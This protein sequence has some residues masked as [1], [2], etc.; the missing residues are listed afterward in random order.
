MIASRG[1][2]IL[3][4]RRH[5]AGSW[6]ENIRQQRL[7]RR[8]L[9]GSCAATKK[10]VRS[11]WR[12]ALQVYHAPAPVLVAHVKVSRAGKMPALQ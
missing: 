5:L 1:H 11:A 7:E 9:A 4:E 8:H 2:N 10:F 6:N 3:L 12:S